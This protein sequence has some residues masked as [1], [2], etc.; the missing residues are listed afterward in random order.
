MGD[1][2]L[3]DGPDRPADFVVGNPPYVRL[4]DMPNGLSDA[5]REACPTMRGRADLYVGFY[6]KGLGMLAPEGRLGFI[7]ADRWM[8]NQYGAKLRELVAANYSVDSVDS[9]VAMHDVEAFEEPVSAYPA[10]TIIRRGEQG[11]SSTSTPAR[12]SIAPPPSGWFRG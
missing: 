12:G 5:Y 8:R 10:V 2:L 6:E 1:F 11:P 4:E 3:S 7:C 9:V